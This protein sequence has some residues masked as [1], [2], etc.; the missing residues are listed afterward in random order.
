MEYILASIPV[1]QVITRRSFEHRLSEVKE[2]LAGVAEIPYTLLKLTF[3]GKPVES[4]RSI[5]AGFAAD[6]VQSLNSALHTIAA[7]EFNDLASRGRL[8]EI[9]GADLRITSTAVGSFGFEFEIPN[10]TPE[11]SLFPVEHPTK[12]AL[13]KFEEILELL[14]NGEKGEQL[15]DLIQDIQQRGIDRIEEFLKKIVDADSFCTLSFADKHVQF[16]STEEVKTSR[17]RLSLKKIKEFRERFIGIFQGT[18]PKGLKFEF[19]NSESKEVITGRIKLSQNDADT[20][21]R[22]LIHKNVDVTFRT[23]QTGTSAPRYWLDSLADIR[24]KRL[25]DANKFKSCASQI[26]L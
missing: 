26:L 15:E 23:T 4:G 6:V 11:S 14:H 12:I 22:E 8:P 2:E 24:Q 7:S 19:F 16:R 18:L 10:E 3:G 25:Y 20:L 9:A 5:N 13:E 21:S 1:E 17:E